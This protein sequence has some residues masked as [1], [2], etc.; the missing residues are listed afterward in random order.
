[1]NLTLRSMSRFLVSAII[2]LLF[3]Y[4]LT[5][6]TLTDS[7]LP[8]VIIQMDDNR[9]IPNDPR[10][11]GNMKII[12]RG[13]GQRNFVSDQNNEDLLDYNGRIEIE[14][15]GSSSSTLEKKQYG[16]ST[17]E[18]DDSDTDNV[19]LLDMP[20][21]ND[22]ILNG[23]AFDSSLVRDY[24]SYNLS[25]QIGQYAPRVKYCEV[26]INGNYRGL[27]LLSEKIKAD[28]NRVDINKIDEL[29]IELPRLSGGYITKTDKIEGNDIAVWS[30]PVRSSNEANFVHEVPDADDATFQQTNYIRGV[31]E[32]LA[33]TASAGNASF[34]T[35]YPS[36][37][38]V[39]SFIDFMLLNEVS[40]NVD[41]YTFSTFFHKDRNGKL[42]A[43]PIWDFNLTYGNDLVMYN[44]DRSHTDIWQFD[45]WDN[46]GPM[47]WKDLFDDNDFHCYLS[48]RWSQLTASG[49]P[50]NLT[51]I[52]SF[53]NETVDLISEASARDE[54][55]WGSI[56]G[57]VTRH[58]DAIKSW[59]SSRVLWMSQHLGS[60]SACDNVTTPP[61]VIT[62]I[63]YR[64]TDYPASDSGDQEFI[65]ILNNGSSEVDLTGVYLGGTG[66]VY[67]FPVG[68]TIAGQESIVIV[69]NEITYRQ[70][71][72]V[73]PFGEF[74]R[75]LSNDGQHIS[76]LDGF[77][78]VIDSL[79]YNDQLPWPV[80]A[81]GDGYYLEL[82]D[83][84]LDNSDAANWM[85][86]RDLELSLGAGDL[87]ETQ[88]Q[89]YPNPAEGLISL[90]SPQAIRFVQL[91]DLNGKILAEYPLNSELSAQI[92]ISGY[93]NGLY[94]IKV[95]LDKGSVVERILLSR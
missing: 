66:L 76:L 39:P 10:A 95:I 85:A 42:R 36:I 93:K 45:N 43:G 9:D 29:D 8:I 74:S 38:D 25:R 30:M 51:E 20:S 27:Y 70:K 33:N 79:T 4:D 83:P 41:A 21:E 59:L 84:D 40:S 63:H 28:D 69:S 56:N 12:Y 11:N 17:L 19:K 48:R 5:G 3:C 24:I 94:F 34:S 47:F 32:S 2:A 1:M 60:H 54:Q 50:L 62:K 65:E 44:L 18:D 77:G 15:R 52:E 72:D 68:S 22:W 67:Q 16:F 49:M 7:N 26:I 71:Y 35:G 57:S 23:L 31:F 37:I 78:N 53:I 86:T 58:T 91:L 73:T 89:I 61:L 81:D 88:V 90:E 82:I 64:P 14:I 6:Q 75:H 80:E 55:R 13:D 92:N 87:V 46:V